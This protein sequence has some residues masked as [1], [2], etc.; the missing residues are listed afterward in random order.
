MSDTFFRY[1]LLLRE[2]PVEPRR[3]DTGTLAQR[4]EAQGIRVARRTLQRDLERLSQRLPLRC[5]DNTKPYGWSWVE[6]KP[7]ARAT[8]GETLRAVVARIAQHFGDQS[9]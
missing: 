4:L 9:G 1:L 3:V 5:H 2:I 7:S 8:K 6:S